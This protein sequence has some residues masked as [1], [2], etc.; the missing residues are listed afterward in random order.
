MKKV[1]LIGLCTLLL[2]AS[3]TS[4]SGNG[5]T[6]NPSNGGSNGGTTQKVK[7]ADKPLIFYN[8]QPSQSEIL[9]PSKG[10]GEIRE[11]RLG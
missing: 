8:R 3:L 1:A 7:N 10:G 4:C 2:G 6:D 5:G 11:N 9:K